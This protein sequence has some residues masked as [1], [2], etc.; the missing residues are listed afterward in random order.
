MELMSRAGHTSPRP[1]SSY[2]HATQD[3]DRVLA[4]ARAGLV[5]PTELVQDDENNAPRSRS[6]TGQVL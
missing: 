3:R 1:L 5:T 2:Q 4:D 6:S